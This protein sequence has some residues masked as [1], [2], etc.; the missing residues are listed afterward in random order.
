MLAMWPRTP[1]GNLLLANCVENMAAWPLGLDDVPKCGGQSSSSS[2]PAESDTEKGSDEFD[3]DFSQEQQPH[4]V[5]SVGFIEDWVAAF[6]TAVAQAQLSAAVLAAVPRA[7]L[8]AARQL[9]PIDPTVLPDGTSAMAAVARATPVA[10]SQPEA[11]DGITGVDACE[12]TRTAENAVKKCSSGESPNSALSTGAACMPALRLLAR[13]LH[14]YRHAPDA[15]LGVAPLLVQAAQHVTPTPQAL[16]RASETTQDSIDIIAT[17]GL[18]DATTSVS[19]SGSKSSPSIAASSATTSAP[20]AIPGKF[21][22]NSGSD[23]MKTTPV[24]TP[25]MT[26]LADLCHTQMAMHPGHP[27][28]YEPLVAVLPPPVE[29]PEVLLAR[30]TATSIAWIN[31]DN[32]LAVVR[33]G[34][35]SL[36]HGITSSSGSNSSSSHGSNMLMST[37]RPPR[38]QVRGLVNL[39]NTCYLNSAL[40]CLAANADF[41]RLLLAE[42]VPLP[43]PVKLTTSSSDS[44]LS[45]SP[46][47]SAQENPPKSM[48]AAAAAVK[49][50]KS[51]ALVLELRRALAVLAADRFKEPT[52]D[53]STVTASLG[54]APVPGS[55]ALSSNQRAGALFSLRQTLRPSALHT[56]LPPPFNS[57]AQQDATEILRFLLD[58]VENAQV[59]PDEKTKAGQDAKMHEVKKVGTE[60]TT[61]D[62]LNVSSVFGGLLETRM[63]CLVCGSESVVPEPFTDLALPLPNVPRHDG[64]SSSKESNKNVGDAVF[65]LP[66]LVDTW[67]QPERLEGENA[68]A[69]SVCASAGAAQYDAE[70]KAAVAAS[71]KVAEEAVLTEDTTTTTRSHEHSSTEASTTSSAVPL[72][73]APP[74]QPPP[75]PTCSPARS[76]A[77][78]RTVLTRAPKHLVVSLGRFG[79]DPAL[80]QRTKRLDA[81][82]FQT[83]L[84][85]PLGGSQDQVG[86]GD[87]QGNSFD[88]LQEGNTNERQQDIS[89]RSN[90][91]VVGSRKRGLPDTSV[92]GD[93]KGSKL[94]PTSQQSGSAHY[95][96]YGVVVHCGGS[97][98]AGH[99]YALARDSTAVQT[100]DV[101]GSSWHL[102]NDATVSL[103]SD[104]ALNRLAS[105]APGATDTPYLLFYRRID[106]LYRN[107]SNSSSESIDIAVQSSAD[108]SAVESLSDSNVPS[109]AVAAC[110]AADLSAFLASDNA[111]AIRQAAFAA[112]NSTSGASNRPPPPA[113]PR[114][115][116]GSSDFG[117]G[118]SGFGGSGFGG[119]GGGG[120]PI[121]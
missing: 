74:Q 99:Y 35:E 105:A 29:P 70:L 23:T 18:A 113:P 30:A 75:T 43:A 93:Q 16:P 63:K 65:S 72:L 15:F 1:E 20:G 91:T 37:I 3:D 116:S 102:Y 27:D 51:S 115:G 108:S 4:D 55:F 49:W 47:A 67:L 11:S 98:Q 42:P 114:G 17:T 59:K 118:P 85:L 79:Y 107:Q 82:R 50:D 78:R 58:A 100:Q 46:N 54:T 5:L 9:V 7:A 95:A 2:S 19:K 94:P 84:T 21:S 80:G 24:M 38:P 40:Q 87:T 77:E 34:N 45:L 25:K 111:A 83:S 10:S 104:S 52:L 121:C 57:F 68:Y 120:G 56:S 73:P 6:L 22:S 53:A 69:C 76:P 92:P 101:D 62:E 109:T 86:G 14:G 48:G 89:N 66:Q 90:G 28:A 117:F 61:I 103:S 96:L 88:A 110:L 26:A 39:G 97:A 36:N 106:N 64:I 71:E 60:E 33:A 119:M 41:R 13:L 81:V 112:T 12:K 32:A 44:T 8:A 31:N